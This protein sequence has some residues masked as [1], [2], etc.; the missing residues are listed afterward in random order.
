MLKPVCFFYWKK[1]KQSS[2]R[3]I[4]PQPEFIEKSQVQ[5]LRFKPSQQQW[6]SQLFLS[7]CFREDGLGRGVWGRGGRFCRSSGSNWEAP[8]SPTS[9]LPSQCV[10][11]SSPHSLL[12]PPWLASQNE[13]PTSEPAFGIHSSRKGF[14]YPW[15]RVG[16]ADFQTSFTVFCFRPGLLL[17][18][19]PPNQRSIILKRRQLSH[20]LIMLRNL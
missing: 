14:T 6:R 17:F 4:S 11:L 1:A 5:Y 10:W 19:F 13:L 9:P 16:L 3:L 20:F 15:Q 12:P 18:C 2:P 7:L 8:L